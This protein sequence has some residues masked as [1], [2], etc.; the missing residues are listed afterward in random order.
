MRREA[1]TNRIP[2]ETAGRP[3]GNW[4]GWPRRR[5]EKE[6]EFREQVS[7]PVSV[8]QK[9]ALVFRGRSKRKKKSN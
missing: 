2:K 4:V 9:H 5:K 3:G 6:R 8:W 1:D 7:W